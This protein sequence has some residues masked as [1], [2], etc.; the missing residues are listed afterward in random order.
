M[1][2]AIF[3]FIIGGFFVAIFFQIFLKSRFIDNK[4]Y[5]VAEEKN[6]TISN[7]IAVAQER[8]SAKEIE[9]EKLTKLLT[10]ERKS[11]VAM[12]D[13]YSLMNRKIAAIET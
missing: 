8:I 4:K 5:L 10:E 12:R 2:L 13:E 6:K 3:G 1:L 7:Q 9:I 11:I